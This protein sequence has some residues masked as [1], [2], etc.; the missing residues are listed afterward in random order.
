MIRQT[1]CKQIQIPAKKET[2]KKSGS[3]KNGKHSNSDEK[4]AFCEL[5]K[6]YDMVKEQVSLKIGQ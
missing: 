5:I 6:R 3:D 4:N 2:M 1:K